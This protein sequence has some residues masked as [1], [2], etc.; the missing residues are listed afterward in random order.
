MT[1]TF[2]CIIISVLVIEADKR[3]QFK[4]RSLPLV[5]FVGVLTAIVTFTL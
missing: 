5:A 2:I 4:Y 1:S 3:T